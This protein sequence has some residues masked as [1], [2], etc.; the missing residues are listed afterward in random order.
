MS[1]WFHSSPAARSLLCEP[2]NEEER[3]LGLG[4]GPRTGQIDLVLC[5]CK[6]R[7]KADLSISHYMITMEIPASKVL[8]GL[9][10]GVACCFHGRETLYWSV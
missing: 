9:H 1:C 2:G 6:A 7:C 4:L 5:R 10:L 8:L 3:D